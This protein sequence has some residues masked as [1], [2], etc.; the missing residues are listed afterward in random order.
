MDNLLPAA[1]AFE[2]SKLDRIEIWI[3]KGSADR[4]SLFNSFKKVCSA[5]LTLAQDQPA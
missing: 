1:H 3:E 5:L 4:S 2:L